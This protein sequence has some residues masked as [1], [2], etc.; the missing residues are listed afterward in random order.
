MNHL[1]LM[2][3]DSRVS[4]LVVLPSGIESAEL[5]NACP[6]GDSHG[7]EVQRRVL[8]LIIVSR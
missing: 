6:G 5:G 8:Y 1:Q 4:R 7:S 2:R 3:L